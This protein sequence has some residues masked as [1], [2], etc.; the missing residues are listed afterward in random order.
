VERFRG[1]KRRR[2]KCSS[3]LLV[4]VRFRV[5]RLKPPS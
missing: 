3:S 2:Y 4:V 1:Q 5:I